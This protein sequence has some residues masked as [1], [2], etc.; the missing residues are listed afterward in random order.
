ML[1]C[2]L[3]LSDDS[4]FYSVSSNQHD[5]IENAL[6]CARK[7]LETVAGECFH[8]QNCTSEELNTGK[9]FKVFCL[10]T[11]DFIQQLTV[12]KDVNPECIKCEAHPTKSYKEFLSDLKTLVYMFYAKTDTSS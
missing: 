2:T 9:C 3:Q 10:Q 4:T 12:K 5:S 6:C 11:R 1:P 8:S 7:E